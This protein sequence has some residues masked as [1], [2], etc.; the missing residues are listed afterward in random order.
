MFGLRV[1]GQGL[2]ACCRM[3]EQA[4]QLQLGPV[5]WIV[6]TIVKSARGRLVGWICNPV[7]QV[8]V[9][10]RDNNYRMIGARCQLTEELSNNFW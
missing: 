10:F 4:Q 6:H 7:G 1:G 3:V 9:P 2:A 5:Q 8:I